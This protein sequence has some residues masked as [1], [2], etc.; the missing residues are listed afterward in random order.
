MVWINNNNNGMQGKMLWKMVLQ[1]ALGSPVV[2]GGARNILW[3][4]FLIKAAN[5]HVMI[6]SMLTIW[7]SFIG[8]KN[9]QLQKPLTRN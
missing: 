1:L 2:K 7:I 6:I 9:L 8:S 4:T 3:W 5:K